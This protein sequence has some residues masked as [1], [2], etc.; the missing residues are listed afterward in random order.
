MGRR[1]RAA[2]Q[3]VRHPTCAA[4]RAAP[5]P[6]SSRTRSTTSASTASRAP[7][8]SRLSHPL[9]RGELHELWLRLAG[10]RRELESCLEI[11]PP[12]CE[13]FPFLAGQPDPKQR[14]SLLRA[15]QDWTRASA[16]D[17]LAA[18]MTWSVGFDVLDATTSGKADGQFFGWLGQA[19]WAHRLPESLLGE[20]AGR[21]APT[22][23][24]RR[25]AAHA[26]EVRARRAAHRARLPRERAGARQRRGRLARA[27]GPGAAQ[28]P[29]PQRC[30]SWC[31]SATSAAA[32]TPGATLPIARSPAWASAC[33]PS[34]GPGCA[35]SSSGAGRL[36]HVSTPG[37]ARPPGRRDPFPG[38]AVRSRSD[39]GRQ[40]SGEIASAT[41][42]NRLRRCEA[43]S[44]AA[45]R[46]PLRVEWAQ[47][48]SGR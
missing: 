39:A 38:R 3:L 41:D 40:A 30:S 34:R 14:A 13:P 28:Q 20:R 43:T 15:I 42:E 26:R 44:Q 35:A 29:G 18:R 36:E 6:T 32:G 8:A 24:S 21:D 1:L 19:Q 17:V 2:A 7:T 31:R 16:N 27:A 10:E 12:S 33:A 48:E 25:L 47:G 5:T 46:V 37:R 4:M 22:S 11:L 9:Y 45:S 23:S